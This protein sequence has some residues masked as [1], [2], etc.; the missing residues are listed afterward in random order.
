MNYYQ[1]HIGDY[2]AATAY[3]SL[4]EDAIYTR[5]LRVYYRDE[6][7]LP[8]D[9]RAVAWLIG[10]RSKKEIALLENLLPQFFTMQA[11]GWHNLR[12]DKEI[13]HY[14]KT[15]AKGKAGAAARWGSKEAEAEQNTGNPQED[16]LDMPSKCPDDATH[17]PESCAG[18]ANQQPITNITTTTPPLTPRKRGASFDAAQIALPVWLNADDWQA[19]V[20]DRKA[21]KKP[22][23]AEGARRQ[24][25][26]LDAY[27]QDGYDPS[28]VITHSIAGGYQGLYPPRPSARASPPGRAQALADWNAELTRELER[29]RP[30]VIDMGAIDATH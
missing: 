20:A 24:I 25:Q 27:R 16:A 23:T 10:L 19:W 21:R 3:L 29:H 13:L 6:K 17:M 22:V 9:T 7:P 30:I 14:R 28:A 2:A 11:D 8:A 15:Q 26:Q 5:L 12:A 18:N 1:H 4:V